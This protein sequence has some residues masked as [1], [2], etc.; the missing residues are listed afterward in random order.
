MADCGASGTAIDRAVAE[1]SGLSTAT[2]KHVSSLFGHAAIASQHVDMPL[3]AP[4]QL[5]RQSGLA[6]PTFLH[7]VPS[8]AMGIEQYHGSTL[9]QAWSDWQQ[10]TPVMN[11]NANQAW[12]QHH[13]QHPQVMNMTSN[14]HHAMQ[15]HHMMMQQQ[16]VIQMHMMIQKQWELNQQH[17]GHQQ[18]ARQNQPDLQKPETQ[19]PTLDNWHDDLEEELAQGATI[20]DLA[21][22][23]AQA[24]A[25]YDR[26]AAAVDL[27]SAYG[28]DMDQHPY[29]FQNPLTELHD[30]DQ[31]W[32]EVGLQEY[33]RGN[34]SEA[35]RAFETLVQLEDDHAKAWYYLGKC[36]AENDLDVL[37]I[38][39]L[40]RSVERDPFSP[41]ALLAL[42]VSH[43]NELNHKKALQNLKE[44]ITHN[45]KYAGLQSDD[46]YG[47]TEESE[48]DQ[49]QGLL[50]RALEYDATPDA[51]EALGVV[52]NVSRDYDAAVASFE[53]ALK[54]RPRDYSLWNKL[55]ATLAN[56]NASDRALPAYQNALK[57]RPKYARA[58]LN[59]AI[60]HSNLQN[61]DQAARCYLQ[62]LSLNPSATHCW[63]YLRIALSCQ[64]QWDLL[65]LVSNQDLKAFQKIYDLVVYD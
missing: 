47:G 10:H 41:E 7:Q 34:L 26:E 11:M 49:V 5:F 17:V 51:H 29:Q 24:E 50:L 59:M 13:Q 25:E 46:L 55:G 48:L 8:H 54:Q 65:P 37:A 19:E 14:Q 45:P 1:L 20:D 18:Q 4:S 64:E 32:M 3:T 57:L 40:E 58:W 21:A 44:W 56:S 61:Y 35:V 16:Q 9:D 23:W 63:S 43:V 53:Q 38:A 30:N 60:S 6:Q 12:S 42:G 28:S 15:Q 52:Y 2:G 62:T 22:A 31:N 39:C 33:N 27:A 36:H